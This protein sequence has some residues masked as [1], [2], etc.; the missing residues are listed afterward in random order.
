MEELVQ[1]RLADGHLS[2]TSTGANL[3]GVFGRS[4]HPPATSSSMGGLGSLL[5][6]HALRGG[7]FNGRELSKVGSRSSNGSDSAD[8]E[9][10]S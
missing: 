3:L 8:A 1:R 7:P 10:A 6:H 5:P 9:H 4:A 2:H